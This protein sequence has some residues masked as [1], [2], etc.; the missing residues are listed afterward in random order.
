MNNADKLNKSLKIALIGCGRVAVK[1]LSAIKYLRHHFRSCPKIELV[2]VVDPNRCRVQKQLQS[3]SH[4]RNI[5]V[6]SD[7][8]KLYAEYQPD[9]VAITTP[10][11]SH[12]RLAREALEN[13]CHILVEKP[14]TMTSQEAIDLKQLAST[15]KLQIAIGHIYRYFPAV[16]QLSEELQRG[17]FGRILYG[18]VDVRWGHDQAYYDQADWRG[19]YSQDGGAIM[20][21]SI[22]AL[23]LM[24]L[25][26]G[27]PQL[28]SVTARCTTQNH[29]MEAEDLGFAI[30]EFSDNIWLNVE[31]TTNT[32]PDDHEANFF[33]CCTAGEIRAGLR[34]GK[35]TL[36]IRKFADQEQNK[37]LKTKYLKQALLDY[38]REGGWRRLKEIKNPHTGI[39]IDLI[40]SI[41][42]MQEGMT[43]FADIDSGINA[44][45]LVEAI[46][47]N[48]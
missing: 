1:H 14:V 28:K 4:F 31:G 47:N 40:E 25:L 8:A 48:R 35:I 7:T 44:V 10:S 41:L 33:V 37:N 18:S 29:R 15:N 27:R 9:L 42:H 17:D 36:D 46:Y 43:P 20:N 30:C 38:W 6:L 34:N 5:A 3:D 26:L 24:H 13:K 39:Y 32:S 11:G 16:K 12:Y 19:T 45:T 23:D 2:A 22:H 21:Q